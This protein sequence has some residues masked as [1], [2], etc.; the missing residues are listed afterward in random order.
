MF[1][2]ESRVDLRRLAGLGTLA[3][4]PAIDAYCSVTE[5]ERNLIIES[6]LM[7]KVGSNPKA[8]KQYKEVREANDDRQNG[9]STNSSMCIPVV[10]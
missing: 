2:A 3:H 7:Q 1:R 10:C 4:Q 5:H 8:M 6:L 9:S